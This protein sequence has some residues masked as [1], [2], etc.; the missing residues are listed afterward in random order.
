MR[1]RE[2]TAQRRVMEAILEVGVE[3]LRRNSNGKVHAAHDES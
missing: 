1:Q 2:S 3:I